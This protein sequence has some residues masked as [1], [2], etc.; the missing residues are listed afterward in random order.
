MA[1]FTEVNDRLHLGKGA[2]RAA[3]RRLKGEIG[4]LIDERFFPLLTKVQLC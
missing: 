1:D 2:N 4:E 3:A